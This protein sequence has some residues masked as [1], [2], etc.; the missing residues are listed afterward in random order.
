MS[1]VLVLVNNEEELELGDLVLIHAIEFYAI[2][3]SFFQLVQIPNDHPVKSWATIK[4]A[5]TSNDVFNCVMVI[6]PVRVYA[7]DCIT[8]IYADF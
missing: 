7:M 6:L 5:V 8:L 3:V 1:F 4:P 2:L